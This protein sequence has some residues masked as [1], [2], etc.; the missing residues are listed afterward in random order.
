[1][2]RALV[3][4]F[5]LH[6]GRTSCQ[7]LHIMGCCC[8][9]EPTWPSTGWRHP[10]S[11]RHLPSQEPL[12]WMWAAT[13]SRECGSGGFLV[14]L[15]RLGVCALQTHVLLVCS[16]HGNGQRPSTTNVTILSSSRC[17]QLEAS[18]VTYSRKCSSLYSRTSCAHRAVTATCALDPLP[19]PPLPFPTDLIL[20]PSSC[21]AL[22]P[23][24][25]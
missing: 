1:M 14:R 25:H 12:G 9:V 6:T 5:V 13:C 10:S 8:G 16:N 4:L 24:V 23:A 21:P 19:C 7:A 17:E 20:P 22:L 11:S 2:A 3:N 15:L 18:L